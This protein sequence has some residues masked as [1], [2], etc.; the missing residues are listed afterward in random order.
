VNTYWFGLEKDAIGLTD[1]SDVVSS[2]VTEDVETAKNEL[3]AGDRI[4]SGKIYDNQGTIRCNDGEMISDQTLMNEM[5]WYVE[6][7]E[8]YG[9]Y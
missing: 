3:V 2:D 6:G 5:D 9:E 1:I 7:V 4:F 8:I